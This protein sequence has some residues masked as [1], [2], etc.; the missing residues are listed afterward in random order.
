MTVTALSPALGY[1]T[2]AKIAKY[3][4][5]NGTSIIEAAQKFCDLPTEKLQEILDPKKMV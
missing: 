1:E 2:A 3:A 5:Q 4:Q